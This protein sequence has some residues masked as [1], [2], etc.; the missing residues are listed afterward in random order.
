MVKTSTTQFSILLLGLMLIAT[1]GNAQHK[2]KSHVHRLQKINQN[3]NYAQVLTKKDLE[4]KEHYKASAFK[5][6]NDI[7]SIPVVFHVLYHEDSENV[8]NEQI[9]SQLQVLN[10]DFNLD[11]ADKLESTHPFYD[12]MGNLI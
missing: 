2:C 9:L 12:V 11:N 6:Q 7:I 8:S 5:K 4:F 3:P 1:I 10:D